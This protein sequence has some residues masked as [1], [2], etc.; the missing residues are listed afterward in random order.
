MNYKSKGY[1]GLHYWVERNLG[2]P[3][4]CVKCGLERYKQHTMHWA[5][6]S[7]EYKKDISDW[8]QMCAKCH[9]AFDND[10]DMNILEPVCKNGHNVSEENL[11]LRVDKR[12][13]R[14][15]TYKECKICRRES[16]ARYRKAIKK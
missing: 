9:K 5:N 1:R 14:E 10:R 16:Q 8:S 11:Y 15:N 4:K 12:P 3:E 2:K 6:I 7:G 13:Y